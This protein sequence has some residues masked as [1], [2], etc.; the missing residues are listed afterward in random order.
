MSLKCCGEILSQ[1][2]IF[3]H[4]TADIFSVDNYGASAWDYARVKQ[5]HY[6]M[7]IIASYIRQQSKDLPENGVNGARR[8]D[9]DLGI[10]HLQVLIIF[11]HHSNGIEWCYPSGQCVRVSIL[12]KMYNYAL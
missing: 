1:N 12:H 2:C 9:E 5:L 4:V 10:N 8:T 7:L 6:S 3:T 11:L